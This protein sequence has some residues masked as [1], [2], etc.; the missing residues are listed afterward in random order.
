LTRIPQRFRVDKNL[1]ISMLGRYFPELAAVTTN[2]ASSLPDWKRDMRTKPALRAFFLE[3][4]DESRLGGVLGELLDMRAVDELKRSFFGANV[5]A[6]A[7]LPERSLGRHLPLRF[8]QRLKATGLY[9]GSRDLHG[10]YPLRGPGDLVRCIALL[11][12]FQESLA[13]FGG[14]AQASERFATATH[15]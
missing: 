11:S 3:R 12:V 5:A 8:K 1:Y 6:A 13:A 4:L 14:E 2:V 9:P 7:P 15:G 10:A